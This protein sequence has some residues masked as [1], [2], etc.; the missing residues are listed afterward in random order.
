VVS[1]TVVL[2]VSPLAEL[3]NEYFFKLCQVNPDL[4]LERDDQRKLIV[5]APV[6]SESSQ[7]NCELIL[8]LGMWSRLHKDLG[9]AFDSSGG[10]V[11]PNGAIRSPDAAWILRTRWEKLTPD[12]KKSFAPLCPDFV[13]ELRSPSDSLTVLQA[14]LDEYITNGAQLGWLLDPSTQTAYVYRPGATVEVLV[15]PI[16]LDADPELPGFSLD[17]AEIWDL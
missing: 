6:G 9:L 12:Q 7:R 16:T 1:S 5:M 2:E 4:R 13:V 3:T 15:S 17:L 14:K 11:L 10:F 8:Q